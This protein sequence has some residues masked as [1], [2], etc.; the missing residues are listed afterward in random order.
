MHAPFAALALSASLVL[1]GCPFGQQ[2]P[3][4][5]A[6]EAANELNVHMRFGRMEL[7]A[8][9][10]VPAARQAFLE[11]RKTWGGH[12]RVADYEFAGFHMKGDND[13]EM[14][15]KIAWYRIDEG[16]LRVTT[17]K[18]KWHAFKGDWKLVDE[19]RS[20]G[21]IGLLG[22]ARSPSTATTAGRNVHFPTIRLGSTPDRPHDEADAPAP[23]E[24][25]PAPEPTEEGQ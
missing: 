5:R 14:L 7:A 2:S 20:D 11:R 8:E 25:T 17:L 19:L 22:E 12:I 21:D 3:A 4:A 23:P 1:T 24:A 6:Q 16:D 18:Q 9:H 13:A 15:V 10:V